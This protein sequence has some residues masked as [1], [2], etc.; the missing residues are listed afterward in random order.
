MDASKWIFGTGPSNAKLALVGEAP[1]AHEEIQG[2]PFVGPAGELVNE[3]LEGAQLHRNSVYITN[4]VKVRPPNNDLDRLPE[5]GYKIEDFHD[6]LFKEIAAVQPNCVL[7][8][9]SL[10]LKTLTGQDGIRN[11]RGSILPC[12]NVDTKVVPT[13]HP[14]ALFERNRNGSS[15]Q[16]M[17]S[18]KQKIHVQFDFVKAKKQS[19]FKGI[20]TTPRDLRPIRTS[21]ALEQFFRT[22]PFSHYKKAYIDTE[23][24]KGHTVCIGIAFTRYEGISVPLIDLQSNEN[25]NGIAMHDY[26]EIWRLLAEFLAGPVGK[27]GQNFNADTLYWLEP[28]GFKVNNY[29]YDAMMKF[30]TLS[31]EL[32]KSLAFQQSILTDE[33]FHKHEGREYNPHKDKLDV[34]LRYNAKDC[35]VNCECDEEMDADLDEFGL[36]PFFEYFVMQAHPIYLDM[37]RT[38]V[39]IDLEQRAALSEKYKSLIE[40]K[41]KA[42]FDLIGLPDP[43]NVNAPT[44]VDWLLYEYLKLPRRKDTSDETLTALKEKIKD[45]R[46]KAIITSI[47]ERRTLRKMKSTYIDAKIDYDG[48][49]RWHT[50]QVGTETGRTSSGIIESP[51]R[52]SKFGIAIQTTPK[53][54][55][56]AKDI[57]SM[58]VPDKGKIFME[59]DQ[60]Q[61]EARIVALLANDLPLLRMFDE[62]D[63]HKWT[64]APIYGIDHNLPKEVL[65]PLIDDDQRQV[66]KAAR[67]GLAYGEQPPTLAIKAGISIYRAKIAFEAVHKVSPNIVDI[68]HEGIHEALANNNKVLITPFGRRREFFNKWGSELF[69]EAYAQLP[70]STVGDSTKRAMIETKKVAPWIEIKIESHDAFLCQVDEDR[71]L[72]CYHIVK[73]IFEAPIDFSRC[74]L[75]RD[76]LVIPIDCKVGYNWRDMQKFKG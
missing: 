65:E 74:S 1:G 34:L 11:W 72:E 61:A 50:K 52:P 64:A 22:Y 3:L 46:K 43:I 25:P 73:P 76:P 29:L 70:Q 67:H 39:N 37:E 63:V 19:E 68:F 53:H 30:H 62:R 21:L 41:D 40:E 60:S 27:V 16:G 26:V 20:I 45:A 24:Y 15:G 12:V 10:A 8:L 47:Q 69:R 33:P 38:G 6:L 36:R 48:R 2:K 55:Q 4:V 14:A 75:P 56:F 57:R 54:G 28:F 31:P 42:A 23:V 17:F 32:P 49:L 13:I 44:K 9:G 59:F 66:G 7:A 58:I 71:V 51:L 35:V 18:W 5:T